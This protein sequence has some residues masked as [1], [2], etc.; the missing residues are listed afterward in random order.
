MPLDRITTVQAAIDTGTYGTPQAVTVNDG[1]IVFNPELT[2]NKEH[3]N[4]SVGD[5]YAR[6]SRAGVVGKRNV[7]ITFS[8][9]LRGFPGIM[10]DTTDAPQF[11]VFMQ[12]CSL[13]VDDGT[14]AKKYE[15]PDKFVGLKSCTIVMNQDGLKW[16]IAGCRGTAVMRFE[17]GAPAMID[18]TFSGIYADP[19]ADA[20]AQMDYYDGATGFIDYAPEIVIGAT[21]T[22]DPY[23]D[24]P[25]AGECGHLS[26]ISLDFRNQII[27]RMSSTIGSTGTG[28]FLITGRG[29]REDP[30]AMLSFDVELPGNNAGVTTISW[31]DRFMEQTKDQGTSASASAAL[32]LIVGSSAASKLITVQLGGLFLRDV[33]MTR[34]DGDRWGHTVEARILGTS[35]STSEDD[36][37]ITCSAS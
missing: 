17:M 25:V 2:V 33:S 15:T 30:G 29:S 34:L 23:S 36:I 31:W 37:S 21:L 10:T 20:A 27:A 6:P 12:A 3:Y 1:F 8:Q 16:S 4:R 32:S 5:A 7:Q 14:A 11:H 9:E 26:N 22:F 13:S 24:A 28:E 18:Y 19:V 35:D